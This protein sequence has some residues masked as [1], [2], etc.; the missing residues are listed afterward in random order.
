MMRAIHV[1]SKFVRAAAN[2]AEQASSGFRAGCVAGLDCRGFDP[3]T[4]VPSAN[5]VAASRGGNCGLT[6]R[7]E[8]PLPFGPGIVCALLDQALL[9][10]L[11]VGY[12]LPDLLAL[13]VYPLHVRHPVRFNNGARHRWFDMKAF[14]KRSIL[15]PS[16]G[17]YFQRSF[18][19]IQISKWF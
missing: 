6:P 2:E 10:D 9:M 11:E 1:F 19:L 15:N 16:Q 4:R 14:C 5:D 18:Q 17:D 3:D 12:T 8:H 7:S 13:R